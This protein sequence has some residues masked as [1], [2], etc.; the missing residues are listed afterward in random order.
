MTVIKLKIELE[1]PDVS[2]STT[3][4]MER[5]TLKIES[6]TFFFFFGWTQ[7]K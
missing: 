6:L 7:L 2:L 3:Y 1:R 5:M 4:E